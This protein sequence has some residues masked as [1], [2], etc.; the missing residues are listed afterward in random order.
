MHVTKRA[1]R[2]GLVFVCSTWHIYWEPQFVHV[3]Y[4]NACRMVGAKSTLSVKNGDIH[5]D[6]SGVRV[7]LVDYNLY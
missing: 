7:S 4:L 6:L 1:M 5:P 3:L 2:Y